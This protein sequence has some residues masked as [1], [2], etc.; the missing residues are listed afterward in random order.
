VFVNNAL[1]RRQADARTFKFLRTVQSLKDSKQLIDILDVE[2][3]AGVP[4]HEHRLP[5]AFVFYA[6]DFYDGAGAGSSELERIR[7]KVLKD[8]LDQDRITFHGRQA[9]DHPFHMPCGKAVAAVSKE[10][11]YLG[12]G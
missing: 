9:G 3:D 8:Q 6:T 12:D 7:Q 2:A 1:H 10:V 5:L 4:D 11:S